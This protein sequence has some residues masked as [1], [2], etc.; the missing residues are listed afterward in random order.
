MQS[1][2]AATFTV[3][4]VLM[5]TII[6]VVE[7]DLLGIYPEYDLTSA[8][9]MALIG[10]GLTLLPSIL[11]SDF[12]PILGRGGSTDSVMK[13]LD[14]KTLFLSMATF[15]VVSLGISYSGLYREFILRSALHT[16]WMGSVLIL[17]ASFTHRSRVG[18]RSPKGQA[19]RMKTGSAADT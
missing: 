13:R 19:E 17:V 2:T 1:Q 3:W 5:G 16:L 11:R 4:M 6:H 12:T 14:L 10:G 8:F 9:L 15:L 7:K 18:N